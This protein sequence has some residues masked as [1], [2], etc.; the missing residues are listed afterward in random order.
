MITLLSSNGYSIKKDSISLYELQN[1]RRKLT[2]KPTAHPDYPEPKAFPVFNEVTN[3]IRVPRCYGIEN[4]N[5]PQKNILNDVF[6]SNHKNIIFKGSLKNEQIVPHDIVLKHLKTKKSGILTLG[7]GSGKTVTCISIASHLKQKTCILVHKSQLLQ[8]WKCEIETFLPDATIGIIQ[9]QKKD[10]TENCDIYIMMIQTLL[11]IEKVSVEFGL[12]VV[13]ECH[14]ISAETFSSVLYKVSAKYMLGLSATPRR[15]DGLTD[16]LYW[17]L[18]PIIYEEKPNRNNQKKTSV[19]I[20]RYKS[21]LPLDMKQY[22]GMITNICN[23]GDR[24]KYILC[25]LKEILVKDVE[26]KRRILILTER[27]NHA[28]FLKTELENMQQEL[29]IQK[30]IPIKSCGI[31][32]GSMKKKLLD[33]ELKKDILCATYNL[34]SEGISISALNT[35]VFAS[36]KKDVVQAFGRIFRKIHTDCAPMVIDI[37]DV[38][39]KGQEKARLATYKQEL[40]E[41]LELRYFDTNQNETFFD[42][43]LTVRKNELKNETIVTNI[44]PQPKTVFEEMLEEFENTL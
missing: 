32:L 4:F 25:I 36:P 42:K 13:D 28:M 44:I 40:D 7:T 9:Q 30:D 35:I 6:M 2:V 20:Y 11:N 17:H 43:K 38:S 23:D 37:S 12:T 33:N 31:V 29:H 39:L 22:A 26:N 1:I 15:K 16:V 3:W 18:G 14:H 21:L 34:M 41:N 10:F 5:N 24:N 19:N 27:R 8:Q